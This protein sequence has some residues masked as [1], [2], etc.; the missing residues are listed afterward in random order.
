MIG[1]ERFSRSP[2]V[3]SGSTA[4][5]RGLIGRDRRRRRLDLALHTLSPSRRLRG[6]KHTVSR[7]GKRGHSC[8]AFIEQPRPLP[9]RRAARARANGRPAH[10]RSRR[11]WKVEYLE[12][13]TLLSQFSVTNLND[14]GG[15]SLRQAIIDSN[16]TTG[17]NEIDFAAG[18]S[19]TITLTSGELKIA[20]QTCRSSVPA[21]TAVRLRQREQPCVRG[22]IGCHGVAL[23]D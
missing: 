21:R 4:R 12:G 19:G 23:G 20:N 5:I 6:V 7:T 17:P 18:L 8:W 11:A 22:R 3:P 2:S 14:S 10:R 1:I 13:R 16:K 15:G 9:A